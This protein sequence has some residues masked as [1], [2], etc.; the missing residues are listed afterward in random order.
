MP[1][2]RRREAIVTGTGE[3]RAMEMRPLNGGNLKAAGYDERTRKL[4]IELTSGTFEYS[5]VSPEIWRRLASASSPWSYFRDN[6]DEEFVAK[7]VR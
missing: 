7:R 3:D 6:V 5:G 4:V 1:P 2:R